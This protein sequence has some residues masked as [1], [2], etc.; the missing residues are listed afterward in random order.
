MLA[1][2]IP[3]VE[4]LRILAVGCHSDD[5][6]IGCSGTLLTLLELHPTA[7]VTWVVLSGSGGRE[8]EARASAAEFLEGASA[9]VRVEGF[10]DGYF[11]YHGAEVKDVFES[12]KAQVEPTLVFTHTERDRHQDH[13]L[14]C[15]LTWNTF[16]NHLIFKSRNTT[17]T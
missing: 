16:R 6:E 1:L 3:D 7:E 12:L 2:P 5:I 9:V 10:R 17:A 8:A 11:P 15:E 14:V 13:R 4:P